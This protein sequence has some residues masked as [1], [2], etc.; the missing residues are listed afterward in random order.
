[1]HNILEVTFHLAWAPHWDDSPEVKTMYLLLKWLCMEKFDL[2]SPLKWL[3]LDP[4]ETEQVTC[5]Y[6]EAD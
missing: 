1:M 4:L 6:A 3:S 2:A 5:S